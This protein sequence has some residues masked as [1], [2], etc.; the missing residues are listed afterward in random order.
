MKKI[1]TVVL[2]VLVF[3]CCLTS[4]ARIEQEIG[5][6]VSV[7]AVEAVASELDAKGVSYTFYDEEELA[8]FREEWQEEFGAEMVGDITSI[9][10]GE[11]FNEET[12]AWID[13]CVFGFSSAED[14][15]TFEQ[16]AREEFARDIEDGKALVVSG[17]YIVNV[18]YSSEKL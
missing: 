4:C 9:L 18:T 11:Y 15:K 17:G 12:G 6:V 8:D 14:V 16:Y 10:E 5:K 1:L 13:Y 2:V 3:A 7:A